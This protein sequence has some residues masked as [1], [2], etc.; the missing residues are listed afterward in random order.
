MGALLARLSLAG[1][2]AA[3]A[4]RYF[5]LPGCA[6]PPP[7]FYFPRCAARLLP[8]RLARTALHRARGRNSLRRPC[9]K[10]LSRRIRRVGS[11]CTGAMLLARAGLLDGRR[12]TTHWN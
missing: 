9:P 5:S 3:R 4:R 11:V 8:R 12:A 7:S 1:V 10:R 6:I 2:L